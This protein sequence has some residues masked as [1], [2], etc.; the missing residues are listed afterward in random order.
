MI[1]YASSLQINVVIVLPQSL[2]FLGIK[3]YV[4]TLL[5]RD[6]FNVYPAMQYFLCDLFKNI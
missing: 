2:G 6:D 3:S 5:R 4:A 1:E